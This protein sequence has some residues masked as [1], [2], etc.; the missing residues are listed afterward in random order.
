MSSVLKALQ[1]PVTLPT[2]RENNSRSVQICHVQGQML[3]T[4]VCRDSAGLAKWAEI[5]NLKEPK[6]LNDM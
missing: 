1:I 4:L 6:L 3:H 5:W 2:E